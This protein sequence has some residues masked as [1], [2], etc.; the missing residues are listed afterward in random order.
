MTAEDLPEYRQTQPASI[1]LSKIRQ[2]LSELCLQGPTENLCLEGDINLATDS[3]LN[4]RLKQLPLKRL[5]PW[6]PIADNLAEKLSSEFKITAHEGRWRANLRGDLDANNHFEADALLHPTQKT[7]AGNITANFDKL[8]WVNLFTEL[9]D[10]P[11][12]NLQA[13]LAL[14]GSIRQPE[15]TGTIKLD[16]AKAGIPMAGTEISDIGLL[17]DL[18]PGHI[19]NLSAEL[20]SGEGNITLNGAAHWPEL[21]RWNAD[22][23]ISGRQFLAADLPVAQVN[24][25]PDLFLKGNEKGINI[26]GDLSIPKAN[27]TLNELANSA[28]N[29]S[30]DET[31]IGETQHEPELTST[32]PLL[33]VNAD[34]NLRLGSEVNLR[35]YGIDT[36]I[37]GK[38]KLR[39]RTGKPISGDGT[40]KLVDGTYKAYGRDLKV[41]QGELYFNGPLDTPQINLRVINPIKDITVGLAISGTPQQPESRLFSTPPMAQTEALSYLLTGRPPGAGSESGMLVNA[42]AKLGLKQGAGRIEKLRTRAKFDTLQVDAGQDITESELVVGKYL[43]SRLYLEYVTKLF[44]DAEVFSLRYEFSDKLHLEAESG[45]ASQ[46]L[47]LIYQFEK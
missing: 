29:T 31:I 9:I 7:L 15:V 6:W 33:D 26:S 21:P 10:Q 40:L 39:E 8:E 22:I 18:Q 35:G 37:E 42:A 41:E 32:T 24:I 25:S 46:A 28:I 11:S 5:S 3:H 38:I 16:R 30:V 23:H 13:K 20:K 1:T 14:A 44:T 47:D 19:A 43:S 4:A 12:G 36:G 17:V 34:I 2:Q 27:I 45:A